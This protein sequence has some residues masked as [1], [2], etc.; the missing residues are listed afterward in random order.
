KERK[1]QWCDR[2]PSIKQTY[3]ENR[4]PS[5]I[6]FKND[7]YI[8]GINTASIIEVFST[9][10]DNAPVSTNS[11]VLFEKPDDIDEKEPQEVLRNGHFACAA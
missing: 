6:E 5:S 4:N 1:Y 11:Y 8:G 9:K 7:L 3:F 10:Q 2:A